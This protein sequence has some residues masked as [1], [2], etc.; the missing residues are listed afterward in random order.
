MPSIVAKGVTR[1][2]M[3]TVVTEYHA[4]A[5]DSV[6]TSSNSYV[7]LPNMSVTVNPTI[8]CQA[9]VMF[10]GSCRQ[11]GELKGYV[12]MGVALYVDG[13]MRAEK[14][15]SPYAD[16]DIDDGPPYPVYITWVNA[17]LFA[18]FDL[19]AGSHTIQMRYKGATDVFGAAALMF[20]ERALQ[21]VLFYR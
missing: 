2:D 19:A 4:R 1:E 13:V 8:P 12:A 15:I 18:A 21:T 9:I 5:T 11:T 17:T 10:S 6:Y 3:P 7:A 16:I 20:R 14:Q